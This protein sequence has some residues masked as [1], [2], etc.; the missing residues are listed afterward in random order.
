M[1]KIC[2]FIKKHLHSFARWEFI[3]CRP[4]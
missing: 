3:T 1:L 4:N 2:I